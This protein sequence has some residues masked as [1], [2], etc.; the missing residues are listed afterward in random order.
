MDSGNFNKSVLNELWVTVPSQFWLKFW[1]GKLTLRKGWSDALYEL[2]KPLMVCNSS[3]RWH[4]CKPP[5]SKVKFQTYAV[6]TFSTCTAYKFTTTESISQPFKDV[7]VRI[8]P[9]GLVKHIAEEIHRRFVRGEKRLN[10]SKDLLANAPS[11]VKQRR[12]TTANERLLSARNLNDAYSLGI[13]QKISSENN[14]RDDLDRDYYMFMHKLIEQTKKTWT[15]QHIEGYIQQWSV[16]PFYVVLFAEKQLKVLLNQERVFCHLDATGSVVIAPPNVDKR[17]FYYSLI[18]PGNGDVGQF[19]V[20]EFISSVHNIVHISHFLRMVASSL[21]KL[22]TRSPVIDKVETDFSLALIHSVVEGFNG[23]SL[24]EYMNRSFSDMTENTDHIAFLTVLHIC[25]SRMI[26]TVL[27]KCKKIF[28]TKAQ[29]HIAGAAITKLIHSADLDSAEKIFTCIIRIFGFENILPKFKESVDFIFEKAE[30]EAIRI[31]KEQEDT[32]SI[33]HEDDE[34]AEAKCLKSSFCDFFER[35]YK[36]VKS[37]DDNL[38][39]AEENDLYCQE[40]IDYLRKYI[41]PYYPLFSVT[42]LIVFQ[43]LRDSNASVESW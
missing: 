34:A 19:P 9:V 2:V 5:Q 42:H 6:C 38:S 14:S 36:K 17:I 16:E 23:I 29:Y 35:V 21:K 20:A 15:G 24:I 13:L 27:R 11:T 30:V 32:K 37:E 18:L 25:S 31:K 7:R 40:Y 3:F 28:K 4:K 43:L 10:I 8:V 26:H 39:T 41:L 22:S 1:A 33:L 12:L